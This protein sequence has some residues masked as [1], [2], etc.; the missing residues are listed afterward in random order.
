MNFKIK[1]ILMIYL[2]GV[3]ISLIMGYNHVQNNF[4]INGFYGR[5]ES[6]E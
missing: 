2:S 4:S 1:K 5:L 6:N 3:I